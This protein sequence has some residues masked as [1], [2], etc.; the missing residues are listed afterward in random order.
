MRV[1]YAAVNLELDPPGESIQIISASPA[2]MEKVIAGNLDRLE[3]TLR[4]NAERGLKFFRLRP[5]LVPHATRAPLD[6]RA[7][8]A[9]RL[10]E[11]GAFIR[12]HDMRINIHAHLAT[13]LLLPRAGDR[14]ESLEELVH[15]GAI[16]DALELPSSDKVQFHL[17]PP[18]DKDAELSLRLFVEAWGGLPEALRARLALENDNIFCR[19]ALALRVHAACGLPIVFDALHHEVD[20]A[21]ESLSEALALAAATWRPEDGLPMVDYSTQ[22]PGLMPG[23][24]ALHIAPGPFRAFIEATRAHDFDLMLEFK[25]RERSALQAL[26]LLS[27]DPRL[28]R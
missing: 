3:R 25:D 15:L 9:G 5:D 22:R 2:R 19:L 4:F 21:G 18:R 8:F 14:A 27:G 17:G 20:H 26:E 12:D 28:R 24:H 16:L 6:W 11:L 13:S 7:R 10:A 23:K 1:G